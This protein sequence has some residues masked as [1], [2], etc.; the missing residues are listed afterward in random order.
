M[1]KAGTIRLASEK[2]VR[3][4]YVYKCDNLRTVY[5]TYSWMHK[6]ACLSNKNKPYC[7]VH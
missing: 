5:F 7:T 3:L 1:L 2:N 4:L 6:T